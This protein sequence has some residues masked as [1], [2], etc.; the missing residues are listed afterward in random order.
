M[1]LNIQ[2]QNFFHDEIGIDIVI[3]IVIQ[4]TN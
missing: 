4:Y 1:I 2:V 3:N